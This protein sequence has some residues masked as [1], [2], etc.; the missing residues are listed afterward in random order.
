MSRRLYSMG[1]FAARRPW[2]VIASWIAISLVVI[3]AAFLTG[4]AGAHESGVTGGSVESE[5]VAEDLLIRS[6]R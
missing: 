6:D 5:H 1:R 4:I 3:S 2:I